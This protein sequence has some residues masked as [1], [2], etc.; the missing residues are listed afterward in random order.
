MY[1]SVD[2]FTNG[3]TEGSIMITH[4][5]DGNIA[6]SGTIGPVTVNTIGVAYFNGT[7]DFAFVIMATGGAGGGTRGQNRTKTSFIATYL[8]I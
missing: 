5:V 8:S 2:C 1:A 6:T 4:S 7:T 3:T